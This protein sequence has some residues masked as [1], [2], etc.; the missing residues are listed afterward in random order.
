VS[1]LGGKISTIETRPMY[2]RAIGWLLPEKGHCAAMSN[3]KL[4]PEGIC[5][6]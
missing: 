2:G 4:D 5:H 6:S 3:D 1:H